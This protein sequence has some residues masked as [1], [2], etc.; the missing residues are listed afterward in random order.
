MLNKTIAL[1]LL[2][3]LASYVAHAQSNK[4]S[5]SK[6][7]RAYY[8]DTTSTSEK[9]QAELRACMIG[10]PFPAFSATTITG[11]KYSD[12]DLKGKV[13]LVTSWFAKCPACIFEMPLLIELDRKYKD[14]GF[15]LLS[16]SADNEERVNEFLKKQP[17]AYDIVPNADSMIQME[18]QTN[19]GYPTNIILNKKGEIVEFKT[20]VP[21]NAESLAATKKR[22][23]PL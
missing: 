10:K 21:M 18:M 14:K 17:L 3:F 9:K 11:K 22:L 1:A 16:F 12:A 19:Y 15:L 8:F 2:C 23:R 7:F 6:C 4:Y 5:L 20:G 13:V